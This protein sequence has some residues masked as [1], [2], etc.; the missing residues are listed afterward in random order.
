MNQ[1]PEQITMT[2]HH[3]KYTIQIEVQWRINI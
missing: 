2:D 3:T 1:L